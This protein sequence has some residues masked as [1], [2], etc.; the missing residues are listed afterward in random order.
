MRKQKE[1]SCVEKRHHLHQKK[2]SKIKPQCSYSTQVR[3]D[4]TARDFCA[5]ICQSKTVTTFILAP[6]K[7]KLLT[8]LVGSHALK[9]NHEWVNLK[10]HFPE[11]HYLAL[12]FF[13][14]MQTLKNIF[15]YD[16]YEISVP[17]MSWKIQ[18][19]DLNILSLHSS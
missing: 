7:P 4:T 11:R 9:W 12:L 2:F 16:F 5:P 3:I 14:Q 1:L 8:T 13:P 6:V 15:V 18:A 19:A 17:K 10:T